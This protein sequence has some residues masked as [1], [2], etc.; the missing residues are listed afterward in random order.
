VRSVDSCGTSNPSLLPPQAPILQQAIS[1]R[2]HGV[3]SS[4]LHAASL[5]AGLRSTGAQHPAAE[6]SCWSRACMCGCTA[7]RACMCGAACIWATCCCGQSLH[8][9]MQALAGVRLPRTELQVFWSE[10]N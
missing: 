7:L 5:R 4:A 8:V 6:K 3:R 2:T 9:L 10:H 1:E